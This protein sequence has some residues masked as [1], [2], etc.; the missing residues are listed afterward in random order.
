MFSEMHG[1]G[2]SVIWGKYRPTCRDLEFYRA[3]YGSH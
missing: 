2:C 1:A 3:A